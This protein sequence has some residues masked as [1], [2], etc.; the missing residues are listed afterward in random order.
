MNRT[1]LIAYSHGEY[2]ELGKPLGTFG[3]S[4]KRNDA[5]RKDITGGN[6]R[7]AK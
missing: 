4:V 1:G 5:T 3:Y 7:D 2:L 6:K